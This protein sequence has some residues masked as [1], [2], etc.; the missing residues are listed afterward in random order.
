M[1]T[2]FGQF[3]EDFFGGEEGT[4]APCATATGF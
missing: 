1:F 3:W 4:H 2:N